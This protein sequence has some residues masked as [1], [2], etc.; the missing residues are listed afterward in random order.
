MGALKCCLSELEEDETKPMT[1]PQHIVFMLID[2]FTHISFSCALEPLR[3]ANLVSGKEL[4][5]WSLVS[6][7]GVSATCS[8]GTV[9]LVDY[10]FESI[11]RSD[12]LFVV[13]GINVAAHATPA[14]CKAIRRAARSTRALGALCSGAWALAKAGLLNGQNAAIHWDFHDA[15]MEQFPEVNLVRSV[16]DTQHAVITASGGSATADLFLHLI[17]QEHGAE[18]AMA[19]ADQ[20]VYNV[21][22]ESGA[23]QKISLQSRLEVR[24][25][26]VMSAIT[27]MQESL[28]EP[29]SMSEIADQLHVSKRQLERLFG[30]YLNC[31]PKKYYMDLR[32]QRAQ[33]LLIQTDA[34]VTD[35]AVACG[36]ETLTHFSRLYKS[37]F[38][39]SP[40]HQ[41]SKLS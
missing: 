11:P 34:S 26:H 12:R 18:M 24:N 16:F 14:L 33:K 30:R 5:R 37:A 28:D 13:T 4:Y 40:S 36:F 10:S 9:T 21:V 23:E 15:F 39:I 29:L 41:S 31:S 8:N 7:D 6:S 1:G 22:R 38:G 35:V 32:L 2:D 20:M 27:L 17:E 19:V 3:I 25:A